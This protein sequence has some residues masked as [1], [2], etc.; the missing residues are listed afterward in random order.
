MAW[1]KAFLKV[2]ALALR[3]ADAFQ[4]LLGGINVVVNLL[5]T[6]GILAPS[7]LIGWLFFPVVGA[8]R[9]WIGAILGG[10]I[11]WSLLVL[12]AA[13]RLQMEKDSRAQRNIAFRVKS[14]EQRVEDIW[15]P[16]RGRRLLWVFQV[17]F[18]NRSSALVDRV[19]N[20]QL[21]IDSDSERSIALQPIVGSITTMGFEASLSIVARGDIGG[22]FALRRDEVKPGSLAFIDTVSL[23]I[24][25]TT[26]TLT[27]IFFDAHGREWVYPVS[28]MMLGDL[29]KPGT[30]AGSQ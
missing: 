24:Q 26:R 30:V 16:E 29:S 27:I 1:L 25:D 3:P 7:G 17:V 15:Q 22:D 28:P 21:R 23:P 6:L 11:G 20:L 19:E 10:V 12:F 14:Y 4:N 13:T 8:S 2:L 5:V 18:T 9:N